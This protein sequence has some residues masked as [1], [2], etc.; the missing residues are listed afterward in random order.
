MTDVTVLTDPF[1]RAL[2]YATHV[3]GGQVRKGTPIPHIAHLLAV[4]ATVLEYDGSEDMAIAALL[5]DS[6]TIR[7][8]KRTLILEIIQ[9]NGVKRAHEHL[10]AVV[11]GDEGAEFHD[12]RLAPVL[13]HLVI[14]RIV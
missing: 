14:E 7:P 6:C 12:L 11:E 10:H 4:A 3:H 1:D 5:R 2:L 9:R 13:L 8:T